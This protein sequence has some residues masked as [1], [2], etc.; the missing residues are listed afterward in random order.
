MKLELPG[1]SFSSIKQ[2]NSHL[3]PLRLPKHEERHNWVCTFPSVI[4]SD[5]V[6]LVL[7]KPVLYEAQTQ[8]RGLIALEN[9]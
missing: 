8:N 5:S 4:I 9:R 7:H 2:R 3:H 1:M 6:K